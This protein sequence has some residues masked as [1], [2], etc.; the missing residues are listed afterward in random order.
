MVEHQEMTEEYEK[1][2]ELSFKL[3]K[4]WKIEETKAWQRSRDR[5]IRE[6]DRN[7]TYFFAKTNQRKRKKTISC[8]E[9]N[10]KKL[11]TDTECMINH[12][13]QFYKT[14]FGREQ[15]ENISMD[16]DF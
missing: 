12:V 4:I 8:L 11:F 16:G 14:L 7:T 13:V 3:D 15:R 9:Y 1:R 5:E 2:K 6:G 10:G